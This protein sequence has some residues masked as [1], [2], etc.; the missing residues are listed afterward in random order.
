LTFISALLA[1]FFG[2]SPVAVLRFPERQVKSGLKKPSE[3]FNWVR[4]G[5]LGK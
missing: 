4:A 3:E 2:A 1:S 5:C